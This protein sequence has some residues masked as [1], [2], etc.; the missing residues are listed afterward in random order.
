MTQATQTEALY[1]SI[2]GRAHLHE[3][4]ERHDKCERG[5]HCTGV[6]VV[7]GQRWRAVGVCTNVV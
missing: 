4:V 3:V 5:M 7:S 1:G 6:Q 2:H